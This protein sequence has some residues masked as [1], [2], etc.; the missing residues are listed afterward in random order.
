MPQLL[1]V[2]KTSIIE[3]FNDDKNM[4]NNTPKPEAK[5]LRI[6]DGV[7]NWNQK[8]MLEMVPADISLEM[9]SDIPGPKFAVPK[10]IFD[11]DKSALWTLMQHG[12]VKGSALLL[13]LPHYL[14]LIHI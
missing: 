3:D 8:I 6:T 11:T 4:L 10:A 2:L 9:I 1:Q 12:L 13:G 5:S 14:S 7:A